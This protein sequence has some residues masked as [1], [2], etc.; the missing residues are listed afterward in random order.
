MGIYPNNSFSTDRSV[1]IEGY[2]YTIS[3]GEVMVSSMGGSFPT[4]AT[5]DPPLVS[6]LVA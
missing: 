6:S 4:V 3:Q 2:L 1:I 5:V